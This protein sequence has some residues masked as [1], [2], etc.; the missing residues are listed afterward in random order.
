MII[1][2]AQLRLYNAALRY[3]GLP[4]ICRREIRVDGAG[5]SPE[6]ASALGD[7]DFLVIGR[8]EM[9]AIIVSP[10]QARL[11]VI[12][13]VH[14][15]D[16]PLIGELY[17][18]ASAQ[19]ANLTK[20]SALVVRLAP[21]MD[22]T[23]SARD[24]ELVQNVRLEVFDTSGV[25]PAAA[26]QRE[27]AKKIRDPDSDAWADP[28]IAEVIPSAQRFGNLLHEAIEILPTQLGGDVSCFG[29][30]LVA[31]GA[32]V[33]RL[34][35]GKHLLVVRE[36][37]EGARPTSHYLALN[38]ANGPEETL[39]RLRSA[40]LIDVP[41]DR[42]RKEWSDRVPYLRRCLLAATARDEHPKQQVAGLKDLDVTRL[43]DK[44]DGALPPQYHDLARYAAMLAAEHGRPGERELDSFVAENDLRALLSVPVDDSPPG[45]VAA[46]ESL[47]AA[48]EPRDLLRFRRG[49]PVG[50]HAAAKAWPKPF[51]DWAKQEISAAS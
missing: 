4:A 42:Y 7:D 26:A 3:L 45:T 30:R 41:H 17:R 18:S 25:I 6:V 47:L 36:K 22:A 28:K 19:V 33:F 37:E 39:E 11:P 51:H 27:L 43:V 35:K 32:W 14:T 50:Y 2:G 29:T 9:A 46:L 8:R 20:W 40:K 44:L 48:V 24:L 13:P 23:K 16:G 1:R 31:G 15:F 38:L 5:W 12:R 10:D 49:D 34:P 21:G